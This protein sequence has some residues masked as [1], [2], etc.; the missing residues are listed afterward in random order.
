MEKISI[1]LTKQYSISLVFLVECLLN[2]TFRH[3]KILLAIVGIHNTA[4]T[5]NN[6]SKTTDK[7]CILKLIIHE[8]RSLSEMQYQDNMSTKVN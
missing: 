5:F 3:I 1:T 7:K 6:S 4:Y 2:Y 8:I